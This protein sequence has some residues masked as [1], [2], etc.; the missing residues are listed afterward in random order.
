MPYIKFDT[1]PST[2]DFLKSY[3]KTQELPDFF[4]VITDHQSKGRGQHANTWESDCCKNILLSIYLKPY[5]SVTEQN[6]LS[7]MVAL[8][9]VKV[10][11]KFNISD[12]KI[13]LPN[14][15]LADGKKIAGVL[16]ENKI[17]G[18]NWIQSIIGIGL[19]V[20]QTNFKN[21]PMATSMK[22]LVG[23]DFEIKQIVD[24]LLGQLQFYYKVAPEQVSKEFNKWLNK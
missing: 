15:I 4:Y 16:I 18:K 12:I 23:Q 7:Q 17:N 14:D 22:T 5:L 3:C 13:K 19:N 8:S 10:L 24:Y 1:I 9:L 11:Q 2:N 20:N 6:I 21:L